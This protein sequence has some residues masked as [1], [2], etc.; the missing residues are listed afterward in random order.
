MPVFV[1][2][3]G[4]NNREEIDFSVITATISDV[5]A[6]KVFIDSNGDTV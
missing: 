3:S 2:G 1:L 5:K 6:G 4:G